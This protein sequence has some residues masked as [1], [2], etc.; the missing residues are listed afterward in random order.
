ME[1]TVTPEAAGAGGP[2]PQEPVGCPNCGPVELVPVFAGELTNYYCPL[3]GTCWHAE[4]GFAVPVDP[5]TCSG[6]QIELVCREQRQL[7]GTGWSR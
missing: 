6:C 1:P 3:C 5:S 4:L 2:A 7:R